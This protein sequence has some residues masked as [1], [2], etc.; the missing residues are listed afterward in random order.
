M[1]KFI[2]SI[3]LILASIHGYSQYTNI[4]YQPPQVQNCQTFISANYVNIYLG[5]YNCQKYNIIGQPVAIG[6]DSIDFLAQPFHMDSVVNVIGFFSK[7][8]GGPNYN[9]NPGHYL[10]LMDSLFNRLDSVG[11]KSTPINPE[12]NEL[13]YIYYYLLEP[14]PIQNFYIAIT[15]PNSHIQSYYLD[16]TATQVD[17]CYVTACNAG[18]EPWISINGNRMPFSAH[19][20]YKYFKYTHLCI[21]PI[22][23]VNNGSS[24]SSVDL[25]KYTYV[26]PNPAKDDINFSCSFMIN[27]IEIYDIMGR[28]VYQKEVK[29]YSK[30]ID[31]SS[32]TKG[33]YVAK[34]NTEQGL[35][36][37]KFIVE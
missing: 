18:L 17:T 30:T 5:L 11:Y 4:F 19:Q 20:E 9:V 23:R 12:G 1:K 34:L 21:F 33:S 24:L 37:K 15:F 29:D 32:L 28:R 25:E 35:V 31:I 27:D 13:S 2:I 3:V 26:Y 10:V 8:G 16:W 7:I 6:S 14:I 36:S 22:L